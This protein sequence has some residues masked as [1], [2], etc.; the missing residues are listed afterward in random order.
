MQ[1]TLLVTPLQPSARN[2]LFHLLHLIETQNWPQTKPD[3]SVCLFGRNC[4]SFWRIKNSKK[5]KCMQT[6]QMWCN[7][8]VNSSQ[9]QKVNKIDWWIL[10]PYTNAHRTHTHIHM[11][12]TKKQQHRVSHW[13][14][15]GYDRN[16]VH[17][18]EHSELISYNVGIW[19]GFRFIPAKETMNNWNKTTENI[20]AFDVFRQHLN[21]N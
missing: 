16:Y 7:W 6:Q 20:S 14:Q 21:C 19:F 11:H 5:V 2:Q 1:T 18:N 4:G 9:I 17:I 12:H 3:H 13:K 15:K 10:S 8:L